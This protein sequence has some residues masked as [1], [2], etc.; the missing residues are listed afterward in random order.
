MSDLGTLGGPYAHA[1]D[2]NDADKV[3]GSSTTNAEATFVERHAFLYS[4]GVMKDLGVLEGSFTDSSASDVNN[5]DQVVGTSYTGDPWAGHAFLYSGG[6]MRDLGT[7]GGPQSGALGINNAG[8]VVG[9]SNPSNE[10]PNDSSAFLYSDGVMRD[11]NSLIPADSGWELA[12]VE[13][14]NDNGYIVGSGYKDGQGH[15]F[16]LTPHFEGFFQPVDNYSTLNVVPQPAGTA[17]QLLRFSLGGGRGP[18]IFADGYPLSKQVACP[19]QSPTDLVEET[20]AAEPSNLTYT[21]NGQ[22]NYSWKTQKAWKGTCRELNLRLKDGTDHKA[23]FR[24][25]R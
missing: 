24:F 20:A 7:L 18:N 11:L 2:I 14:I 16:L 9:F 1:T 17:N 13:D 4:G 12:N 3:V 22:Y 15:A 6:Q 25:T 23:L 21:G 5:S 19:S 10:N 8:K